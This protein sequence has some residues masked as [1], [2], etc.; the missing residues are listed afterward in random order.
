LRLVIMFNEY[1]AG[2]GLGDGGGEGG[3]DGGGGGGALIEA[4]VTSVTLVSSVSPCATS[5]ALKSPPATAAFSVVA[6]VDVR[7]KSKKDTM[8]STFTAVYTRVLI[9]NELLD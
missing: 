6:V 9:R 4:D 2:G 5:C 7:V 1:C 3:G 8:Y